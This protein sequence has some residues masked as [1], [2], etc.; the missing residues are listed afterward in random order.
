MSKLNIVF[1]SFPDYSSN[2][3]ALYEYMKNR[4]KDNMNL[5]W[6]VN[7]DEMLNKLKSSKIEVY[8]LGTQEYF[9]KMKEVDVFFTTHANIT[10][11]KNSH[12]LYIELWHGIGPNILVIYLIKCQRVISVGMVI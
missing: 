9:E 5:I 4:Y 2:A 10:G 6:V 12:A 8:K 1:G 3:K 11:E 7:S